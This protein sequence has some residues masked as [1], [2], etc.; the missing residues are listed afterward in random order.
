[1]FVP[2]LLL[3]SLAAYAFSRAELREHQR[4]LRIGINPWPGY[5]FAMLAEHLGYFE[6]VGIEVQMVEFSS[7]SDSRRAYERGQIDG[8]FGTLSE[9]IEAKEHAGDRPRIVLV[10]DYSS[11]SDMIVAGPSM[12]RE[13]DLVGKRIGIE[14]GSLTLY[15][16]HRYLELNN[17]SIEDVQVVCQPQESLLRSLKAGT[18]DAMVTYPPFAVSALQASGTSVI[19][20]S[21]SLPNE[22]ADVLIVDAKQLEFNPQRV[23]QFVECFFRAVDFYEA[24]PL[25]ALPVLARR[26]RLSVGEIQEMLG[27]IRMLSRQQQ[28][29]LLRSGSILHTSMNRFAEVMQSSG[30]ITQACDIDTL[31]KP[32]LSP[33]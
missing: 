12:H 3:A 25:E 24:S 27:G 22:I 30:Q 13:E 32:V 19:F 16:L 11:G 21:Q 7:L 31:L 4:P 29:D 10:A 26:E 23:A 8:F 5:E 1:M 14:P 17:R 9:A 18:I 28:T 15:M 33:E 20:S 6:E 2:F